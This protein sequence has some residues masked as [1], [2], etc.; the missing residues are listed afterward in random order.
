MGDN[1]GIAWTEA[2]WN[3]V[4]GCSI[5]SPGC[6]RCYAMG[7]AMR[8][9]LMADGLGRETHYAGTVETVKGRAIWT[10]KLNRAPERILYQPLRWQRPRL[11]F[12]NSMSDLFHEDMPEEWIDHTFAVM[13]LAWWHTFQPLTKRAARMAAYVRDPG[14]P[15]RVIR[16][17]AKIIDARGAPRA[18]LFSPS[19]TRWPLANVWHGVSAEDQRRYDERR[20]DF[21]MLPYDA[22]RFWSLEP[23]IGPISLRLE[24]GGRHPTWVIIGGESA[25]PRSAARS[26]SLAWAAGLIL[27]CAAAGVP[28]FHKQLGSWPVCGPWDGP[29]IPMRHPKGADPEEWPTDLRVRQ[30]PRSYQPAGAAG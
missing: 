18:G 30:Y 22:L 4:V 3:P 15:G 25:R 20:P 13:A 14:T 2:T 23:L 6:T 26:Y 17:A 16:E 7:E 27:E 29:V 12:V 24:T 8:Q 28:L 1:S 10:G 11:I 9:V 19:T 21:D 5:L